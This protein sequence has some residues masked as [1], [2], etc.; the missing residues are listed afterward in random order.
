MFPMCIWKLST[1]QISFYFIMGTIVRKLND[2]ER[3]LIIPTPKKEE[4]K[5]EKEM[6]SCK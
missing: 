2:L 1:N 6:L 4:A 5:K 3:K